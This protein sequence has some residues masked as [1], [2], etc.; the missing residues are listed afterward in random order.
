M[1]LI[2]KPIVDR[3]DAVAPAWPETPEP[4]NTC[5]STCAGAMDGDV[6]E[7]VVGTV[8]VECPVL[9]TVDVVDFGVFVRVVV[10]VVVVCRGACVVV[11]FEPGKA[12]VEPGKALVEWCIRVKMTPPITTTT[13][14]PTTILSERDPWLRRC[15]GVRKPK[16]ERKV[17]LVTAKGYRVNLT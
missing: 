8:V 6:V 16:Y 12:L 7:T 2:L 3:A 11:V 10:R 17:C 1:P 5:T 9:V 13:A 15:L 14:S 4:L